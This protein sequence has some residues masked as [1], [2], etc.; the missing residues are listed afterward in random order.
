MPC[1]VYVIELSDEV[2]PRKNQRFPNVYVGETCKSREERFLQHRTGYFAGDRRWAPF[3]TR[4]MPELFEH[5][6]DMDSREDAE[7][8]AEGLAAELARQGYTV[9]GQRG[10]MRIPDPD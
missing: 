6:P 2:G 4:L 3:V 9:R 7:V 5:L 8:E 10:P 1:Y